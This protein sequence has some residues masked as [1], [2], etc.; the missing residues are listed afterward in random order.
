MIYDTSNHF[1]TQKAI[2][3]FEFL[4]ENKKTIEIIDKKLKRTY[5]QN[6]YLH[7]LIGLFSLE[8]GYTLNEGK[9]IYKKLSPTIYI[10]EK[11]GQRFLR[12]SADLKTDEMTTS[13]E[14]FRNYSSSELG[15][16]LP[17]PDEVNFL[18]QIETQIKNNNHY[19]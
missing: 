16:Y 17:S 7:L 2:T 1:E 4:C 6:R 12:S 10:Y 11:K 9:L 14:K 3:R 15:V 8:L 5:K 13:I 18:N 19:L